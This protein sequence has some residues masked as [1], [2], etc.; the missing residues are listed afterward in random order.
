MKTHFTKELNQVLT[1]IGNS[2]QYLQPDE[3]KVVLPEIKL[4]KVGLDKQDI[5]NCL[6]YLVDNDVAQ[7]S[8]GYAPEITPSKMGTIFASHTSV[9]TH[10][11]NQVDYILKINRKK[12]DSLLKQS[13]EVVIKEHREANSNLLISKDTRGDYFYDGKKIDVQKDTIYYKA[14][15][16]LFTNSDQEGFLS[17][18]DIEKELIEKGVPSTHSDPSRN[19]RIN[20]AL[21]NE[22]EGFFRYAKV[23]GQQFKNLTLNAQ[24]LIE[25]V[26]GKGLRLNNPLV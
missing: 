6:K 19:K 12:L 8:I 14:F 25:V 1:L 18:A 20:N 22:Q 5:K 10:E 3:T 4:L 26:R 23:N 9:R 15:D 17:Y 24:K 11:Y 16:I 21:I 2:L 13:Q 7:C